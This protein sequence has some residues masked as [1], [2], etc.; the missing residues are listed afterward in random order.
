MMDK[1]KG[2]F[3]VAAVRE[4]RERERDGLKHTAA[5]MIQEVGMDWRRV[6]RE[7]SV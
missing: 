6:V 3:A 5:T 7:V 1:D 2:R 4:R